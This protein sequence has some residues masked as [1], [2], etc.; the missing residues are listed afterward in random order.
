MKGLQSF[1]KGLLKVCKK[2]SKA[3]EMT[4]NL[5]ERRLGAWASMQ[6]SRAFWDEGP[7][8]P[9]GKGPSLF[10]FLD[11]PNGSSKNFDKDPKGLYMSPKSLIRALEVPII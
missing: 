1:V 7:H 5:H 6:A 11:D 4:L 8:A 3:F 9:L 10:K 2:P